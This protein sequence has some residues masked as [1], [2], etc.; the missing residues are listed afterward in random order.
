[1]IY[2]AGIFLHDVSD[3]IAAQILKK[4][5]P[6][7]YRVKKPSSL[8]VLCFKMD[9]TPAVV[10][11]LWFEIGEKTSKNTNDLAAKNK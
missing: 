3:R 10:E 2:V 4:N 9:K 5:T 1:L 6:S 11:D 7:E 8:F